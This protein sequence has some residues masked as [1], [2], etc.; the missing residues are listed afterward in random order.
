MLPPEAR[1]QIR[2][3]LAGETDLVRLTPLG[4]YAV[5]QRLLA[6]G[7]YVPLV[8]ELSHATAAQMLGMIAEHHGPGTGREEID[9]WLAAHDADGVEPLLDA[10]RR[11]AFRSRAAAMLDV[12]AES[13]P[14]GEAFLRT[15]RADPALAPIA[16]HHMIDSGQLSMEDLTPVEGLIG[17]AEQLLQ[18]L[19]A[20][21]PEAVREALA[22]VP[23]LP[24][25]GHA[26]AHSGH[27]DAQG[28]QELRSLVIEPSLRNARRGP[29]VV[30]DPG[31]HPRRKRPKSRGKRKR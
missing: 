16:I 9:R 13:R 18:V 14:D 17:M 6:E 2:A 26:L 4:T 10:V 31:R 19:E 22:E 27:P 24:E 1:Q 7:R 15:L 5:R 23:D 21:G 29:H 25:L 3:A 20:E 11:C 8:G 30:A 28:L 12:L